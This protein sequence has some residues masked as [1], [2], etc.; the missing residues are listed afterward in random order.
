M[1]QYRWHGSDGGDYIEVE[2]IAD[3]LLNMSLGID[4]RDDIEDSDDYDEAVMNLK[5]EIENL[6]KTSGLYNVLENIAEDNDNVFQM[7]RAFRQKEGDVMEY[8]HTPQQMAEKLMEFNR[9][10]SDNEDDVKSETEYLIKLFDELQ[11]S[12]QFNVLAHHLDIMFMNDAFKQKA[13]FHW[14]ILKGR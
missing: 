4:Y 11:N 14:K 8:E 3:I 12:E 1:S 9:D 7:S 10:F 13:T 2:K 6:D 5:R